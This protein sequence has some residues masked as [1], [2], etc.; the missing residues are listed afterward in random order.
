MP[1]NSISPID[2]RYEKYTKDLSPYFSESASMKYKI[3]IECEYLITLL[4]TPKVGI[5]KLSTKEKSLIRNVYEKFSLKDAQIINDIE[6]KGYKNIKATNHDFKAIEY[7]IKEKLGKTS[8]KGISE[9]VHF[10]LT[11][12]DASNT[13]YALM[14]SEGLREIYLP[15]I[16][17]IVSKI[18]KLVK[19][20]KNISMLARTHG[21]PASPTTFGKEF[22]VFEERLKR[23]IV[24]LKNH[25]VLAKLNGATGNYNALAVAYPKIDWLKFSKTFIPTLGKFRG[26]QIETNLY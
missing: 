25:K 24:Q 15:T 6:L 11:S 19:N 10:G 7:F 23:Q 20:N 8:L 26:V 9:F 22:K 12:E 14:I 5:R 3:L 4:E 1:L 18:S 17:D 13:A 16:E 2:G 21:Q